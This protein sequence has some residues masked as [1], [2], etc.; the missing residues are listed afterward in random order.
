[1]MHDI[2]AAAGLSSRDGSSPKTLPANTVV[3]VFDTCTL[4]GPDRV[5]GMDTAPYIA[6]HQVQ[7][8]MYSPQPDPESESALEK[9]LLI[10]GLLFTKSAR[11]Y[12]FNVQRYLTTYEL[13]YTTKI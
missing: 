8:E 11:E 7:L 6:S 13:T 9:Q 4:D 12:A 10:N 2:L 1:M 3:Y 5:P